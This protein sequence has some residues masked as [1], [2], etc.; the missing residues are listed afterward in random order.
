VASFS[1][2]SQLIV[3]DSAFL[4][5]VLI[6]ASI[7]WIP[8]VQAPIN[9]WMLSRQRGRKAADIIAIGWLV[10]ALGLAAGWASLEPAPRELLVGLWIVVGVITLGYA[11]GGH[12][13]ALRYWLKPI[14]RIKADEWYVSIAYILLLLAFPVLINYFVKGDSGSRWL[15][16]FLPIILF[17]FPEYFRDL[18]DRLVKPKEFMGSK[19]L[20]RER[21]MKLGALSIV[22]IFIFTGTVGAAMEYQLDLALATVLFVSIFLVFIPLRVMA[23]L[24]KYTAYIVQIIATIATIIYR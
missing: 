6:I 13:S 9:A 10:S 14:I 21:A 11:T 12:W 20:E 7:A 15:L 5:F 24:I 18:F 23:Y 8:F 16:A 4:L 3:V 1:I 19:A 2:I 22:W 17:N